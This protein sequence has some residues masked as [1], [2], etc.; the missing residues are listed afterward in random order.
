LRAA[1]WG[2]VACLI[3]A[4]RGAIGIGLKLAFANKDFGH[5]VAWLAGAAIIPALIAIAGFRLLGGNGRLSGSVAVLLVAL[6]FGF[7]GR[8]VLS[9]ALAVSLVV[10]AVLLL[11][12]ANG[13][14]GALALRQ[15][16]FEQALRE[17]F[18]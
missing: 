8:T 14:R 10:K 3:T 5:A 12:M 7:V 6:D 4:I 17:R 15:V 18:D 13:V 9:P 16:D 2:G 11:F 1:R